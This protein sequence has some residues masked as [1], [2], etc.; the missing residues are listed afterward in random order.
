LAI[1]GLHAIYTITFGIGILTW[2]CVL[3]DDQHKEE[4][5]PEKSLA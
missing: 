1:S 4:V 2:V 5:V 3:L